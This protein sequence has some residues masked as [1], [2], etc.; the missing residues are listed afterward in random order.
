M[1]IN[2]KSLDEYLPILRAKFTAVTC[3]LFPVQRVV[4]GKWKGETTKNRAGNC[5]FGSLGSPRKNKKRP[6]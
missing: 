4:R 5:G 2:K 1:Y 6:C 3:C